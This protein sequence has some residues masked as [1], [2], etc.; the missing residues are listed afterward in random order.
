M[1]V[2]AISDLHLPL[3]VKKPMDIFGKRWDHYVERMEENWKKTIAADDLVIIPGDISWA[4]Y[5]EEAVADLRFIDHLPG[6]KVLSRGNHDYWWATLNKLRELRERE[7][8]STIHFLHNTCYRK[9]DVVVCASR[10]WI[11]PEDKEFRESDEKIYRRELIRLELSLTEAKKTGA[12]QLI[13]A[14]HYPPLADFMRLIESFDAAW[15]VY[16][17]LHH[18]TRGVYTEISPRTKLVSSDY[19]SFLP[20][21][22]LI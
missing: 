12:P 14:M 15:V 4:T 20:E 3:G 10:G 7:Q 13:A 11:T 6:T 8:L 5:M 2:F 22:I 9:G 18:E 21:K 1:A 19:L 17:H 16:G